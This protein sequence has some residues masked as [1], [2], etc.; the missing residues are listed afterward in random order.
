MG[1][2]RLSISFFIIVVLTVVVLLQARVPDLAGHWFSTVRITLED[3]S[4]ATLQIMESYSESGRFQTRSKAF[5]DCIADAQGQRAGLWDINGKT[6]KLV[7]E[8]PRSDADHERIYEVVE[9]SKTVLKYRLQGS[10]Q[11]Y[12]FHRVSAD[13]QFPACSSEEP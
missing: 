7:I 5:V 9:H 6:L 2:Y 4:V 11:L 8:F 10:G 12:D 3:G 13:F 1:I